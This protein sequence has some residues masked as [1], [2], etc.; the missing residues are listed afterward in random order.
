M[1][2]DNYTF[3][4]LIRNFPESDFNIYA[5]NIDNKLGLGPNSKV[6]EVNANV[7]KLIKSKKI[8]TVIFCGN[9]AHNYYYEIED[10]IKCNV[11][12]MRHP[13]HGL[14]NSLIDSV[15]KFIL[16]NNR[17]KKQFIQR[18]KRYSVRNI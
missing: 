18:E 11:I 7:P 10:K 1:R 12:L 15:R 6:K 9:I 14:K 2:P 5:T 16:E 17:Y 13:A 8:D 3:S 4:R